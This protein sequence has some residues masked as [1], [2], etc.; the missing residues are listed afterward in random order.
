MSNNFDNEA[1]WLWD[2]V[3]GFRIPSQF[4]FKIDVTAL[5]VS[6]S[7]QD[8]NWFSGEVL[9]VTNTELNHTVSVCAVGEVKF[10]YASDLA[11]PHEYTTHYSLC[12]LPSNKFADDTAVGKAIDEERLNY[13]NN[14]WYE[15]YDERTDTWGDCVHH[16]IQEALDCAVS[17]LSQHRLVESVLDQ[18]DKE[19][20]EEE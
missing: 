19:L 8:S 13:E 16:E 1:D 11:K 17:Q 12:E 5:E 4:G 2:Y 6:P 9:S 20:W 15:C 14:N 3:N 10:Q 18:A 7:R